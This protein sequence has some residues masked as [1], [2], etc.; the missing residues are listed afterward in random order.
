MSITEEKPNHT[1]FFSLF[2]LQLCFHTNIVNWSKAMPVITTSMSYN[3]H[4]YESHYTDIKLTNTMLTMTT[5][6]TSDLQV[7]EWLLLTCT[8]RIIFSQ[9]NRYW[10]CRVK[11]R[12]QKSEITSWNG[13]DCNMF[14]KTN[15]LMSSFKFSQKTSDQ[16]LGVIFRNGKMR[17][18]P[19]NL[20][21]NCW[22]EMTAPW[23]GSQP[24]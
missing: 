22:T 12:E 7:A 3:K 4:S 14:T 24:W 2:K 17:N 5:A 20:T 23:E 21:D 8:M 19:D 18:T 10:K 11:V 13:I 9:I 1:D 16:C 6:W 15:S